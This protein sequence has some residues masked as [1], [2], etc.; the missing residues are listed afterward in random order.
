MLISA[1][2]A[3]NTGARCARTGRGDAHGERGEGEPGLESGDE[4][5]VAR[6]KVG[7]DVVALRVTQGV[8]EEVVT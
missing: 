5:R 1:Y 2:S 7:E 8:S 6:G 3:Y 4:E